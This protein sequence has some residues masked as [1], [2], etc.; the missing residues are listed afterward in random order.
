MHNRSRR[1]FLKK[2]GLST[3]VLS[4]AGRNFASPLISQASENSKPIRY[5]IVG[6]GAIAGQMMPALAKAKLSKLTGFVSG[7]PEKARH[8]AQLYGVPEKNIYNYDNFDQIASNPDID[9]VYVA[10]PNSMHAEYTIRAAKAGKHVLCEKP[11]CTSVADAQ[12]MVKACREAN[13]R[14]MV[15]YRLHFER[16]NVEAMRMCREKQFGPIRA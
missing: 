1:N 11:M 7:H 12:A 4:A 3:A 5:A 9:A 2:I 13:R 15:A 10:L 6:I 8:F 14:L 16:Y